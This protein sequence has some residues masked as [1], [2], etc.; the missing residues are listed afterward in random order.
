L[1]VLK[2][3]ARRLTAALIA[4]GACVFVAG[5]LS[6]NPSYF[7]YLLPGGPAVQTHPKPAGQGY[8]ADYDP[9]AC[10][11][12]LRPGTCTAPIR[13]SQVFIATVY[14]SEG[15]P[16]RKRRVE[17]MVEGPGTIVEVDESGYLPGRGM[18]VDNKYAFSH[19]DFME[20]CF[21]RGTDDPADD[22]TIG[23]GQTWCVVSSAVEGETVVTA[24]V[25]AI[26]D[27]N[28]NRAYARVVWAHGN[29]KFPQPLTARAGGECT[30][31]TKVTDTA[32]NY[33]IRYRIVDGP[34]AALHATKGTP[35]DSVTE[36]VTTIGADGT[37]TINVVQPLASAGTNRIAIEV[38]KPNADNPGQFTV[39]S[40]G[41]TKVTWQTAQ[42]AITI[43]AP[44][45]LALNQDASIVYS[46][47][48]KGALGS[49]TATLTATIPEGMNVVRT[50]P[51]AVVD[52][53]Q[54]IWTLA[55]GK[56]SVEA[57][58]RPVV[59]G[60]A[61]LTADVRS[62]NGESSRGSAEVNVSEAKL[63][64][65]VDG[66][67]TA[68]VGEAMSFVVRVTNA[69]DAAAERVRVQV[70]PDDGLESTSKAGNLDQTIPTIAAGQTK[71]ITVNLV[72]KK[73]GKYS[74]EAG[75]AGENLVAITQTVSV[76]VKDTQLRLTA[77]G[78]AKGYVGQDVTWKLVVR[79]YGDLPLGRVTICATLPPE[80]RFLSASDGGKLNG[81]QVTWDLGVGAPQ[82]EHV[83]DLTV[84]CEKLTAKTS[85]SATAS[86][87]PQ[88][89]DE[90]PARASQ[91]KTISTDKPA[92][93][94]LEIVGI[95]ALQISVQDS[96]DPVA[97]GQ[98]TTYT[99]RV[100]NAGTLP[101]T[102]VKVTAL[103]PEFMKPI[104]AT[105]PLVQGVIDKKNITFAAIESLA[106]GAESTFVIVVEGLLAGDGRFRAEASSPLLA[107]PVR[108][109]EPTR[110]L[111][112]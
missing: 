108:A 28:K 88:V 21:T 99:V 16:R 27:W 8:F 63:L 2:S 98:E 18:K 47:N 90:R 22:F 82:Q 101:A 34:P 57:V 109:E 87:V 91:A 102:K 17:W 9:H 23:P 106:P 10:R 48:E 36:A 41:E 1:P 107:Q 58:L 37:A 71:T 76:E 61:T 95:P 96:N 20:H 51:R 84:A 39:V 55:D 38:I 13:S 83:I 49:G 75:A 62:A 72:A 59:V 3:A 46:V 25:P 50:E 105:G 15:V 26:A 79:N 53:D 111:G 97:I 77:I 5:C 104:R 85:L 30:F 94:S 60:R 43:N 89:Q 4:T 40:K 110:V 103:V 69:G 100:K 67:P 80:V 11:V 86:G 44:K 7:P 52:G 56:K 73:G 33:R 74:V 64:V 81:R 45:S 54:M 35:V 6:G 78:P 112:R 92:T 68:I 65:K 32:E 12:E 70:R 14:D 66:P 19:T 24:Y 42:S 29:M 31:S 93:A